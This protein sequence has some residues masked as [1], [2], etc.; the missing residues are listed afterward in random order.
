MAD[1]FTTIASLMTTVPYVS[2]ITAWSQSPEII[3]MV[4]I[5]FII[6]FILAFA[7]G[8]NDVANSFGTSVGSKVLTLKQA[9]IYAVIFETLGK[10]IFWY[11]WVFFFWIF[12]WLFSGA[13]LIGGR[14]SD[15]I[16]KEIVDINLYKGKEKTL[17]LGEISALIGYPLKSQTSTSWVIVWLFYVYSA[18]VWLMIATFMKIPVSG[19]IYHD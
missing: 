9:C 4:V 19:V 6:A 16:W 10:T 15:T 1:F 17:M 13:V 7:V 14:V 3:W 2:E 12:W 11:R 8:A 5:G 18:A